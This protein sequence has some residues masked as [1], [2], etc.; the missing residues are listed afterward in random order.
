[1]CEV[2]LLQSQTYRVLRDA[3]SF[4]R[5][6]STAG[7]AA[8]AARGA[9]E[10][11]RVNE[12]ENT[13]CFLTKTYVFVVHF[14]SLLVL[15]EKVSFRRTRLAEDEIEG[16]VYTFTSHIISHTAHTTAHDAGFSFYT[17]HT[18][19]RD[20]VSTC[21]QAVLVLCRN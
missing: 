2:S 20:Y 8:A 16:D 3:R 17:P 6:N 10:S 21:E 11:E 12:N 1:M 15:E 18:H 9:D 4:Q 19:T 13:A 5:E 7:T 14:K